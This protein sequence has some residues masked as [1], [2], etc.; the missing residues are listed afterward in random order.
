MNNTYD[1]GFWDY[2]LYFQI[3]VIFILIFTAMTDL[4]DFFILIV[5]YQLI[6]HIA[7]FNGTVLFIIL[8]TIMITSV[9]LATILNVVFARFL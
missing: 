4:I 6:G 9:V 3:F 7:F 8:F 2:P 5:I 1:L